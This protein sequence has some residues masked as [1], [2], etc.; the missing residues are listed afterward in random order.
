MEIRRSKKSVFSGTCFKI[1]QQ[2]KRWINKTNVTNLDKTTESGL[3]YLVGRK[4]PE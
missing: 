4:V 3:R 1:L 2:R